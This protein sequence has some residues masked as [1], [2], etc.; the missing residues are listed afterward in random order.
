ME[1]PNIM[2]RFPCTPHSIYLRGTI[3]LRGLRDLGLQK[4]RIATWEWLKGFE[5][6]SPELASKPTSDPLSPFNRK[7]GLGGPFELVIALR[8]QGPK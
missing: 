4:I 6:S 2:I 3:G 5:V 8:V 7:E 1:V